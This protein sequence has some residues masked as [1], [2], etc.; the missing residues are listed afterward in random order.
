MSE[1]I[2]SKLDTMENKQ[3]KPDHT[4]LLTKAANLACK[5]GVTKPIICANKRNTRNHAKIQ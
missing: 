1:I 4:I 3:K 2:L 5:F